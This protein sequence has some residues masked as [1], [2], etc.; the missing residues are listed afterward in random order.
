[1]GNPP[2]DQSSRAAP[3]VHTIDPMAPY[4]KHRRPPLDQYR[5][6]RPAHDGASQLR[7]DEP[8]VLEEQDDFAYQVVG[9]AREPPVDNR[10]AV[11][12]CWRSG[13]PAGAD[14]LVHTTR[15]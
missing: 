7:Q 9:T 1:M 10:L 12:A 3:H 6:H 5:G 14:P 13:S 15:Q 11:L 2:P 8:G 4:N